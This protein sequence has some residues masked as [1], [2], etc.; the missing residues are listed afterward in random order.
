MDSWDYNVVEFRM[1]QQLYNL[2]TQKKS[3]LYRQPLT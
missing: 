3:H 1:W 2:I